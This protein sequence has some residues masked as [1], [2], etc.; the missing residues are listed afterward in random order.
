MEEGREGGRCLDL[1]TERV[2]FAWE[3]ASWNLV[4]V[5]MFV[6]FVF[7]CIIRPFSMFSKVDG[8]LMERRSIAFDSVTFLG[9]WDS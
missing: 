2:S 3:E 5:E 8:K 7:F 1:H 6:L 9:S 4:V